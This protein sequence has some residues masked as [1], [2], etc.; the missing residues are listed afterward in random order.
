M[1]LASRLQAFRQLRRFDNRW[2]LLLQ[3][4]L[5]RRESLA[6][7]RLGRLR[8]LVDH[9]AGDPSGAPEVLTH[10]M[11]ADHRA[12]LVRSWPMRVLDLGANTGGFA[13]FLAHHGVRFEQL[14]AV[15]LNPRTCIRL[16]Y[17]LESNIPA[18]ITVVNAGVCGRSRDLEVRLGEGSVADSLYAPSFNST[19]DVSLVPGLTIDDIWTRHFDERPVDICKIDIE[20]AEYEVFDSP[21][22]ASL[23]RCRIV[24]IEIHEVPGRRAEEVVAAIRALGFEA[25]PQGEDRSVHVFRNTALAGDDGPSS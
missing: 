12:H 17:N 1:S 15:E 20:Q 2:Q 25:L 23:R 24:V 19:G 8:F 16:R 9:D 10:P 5:F 14:V 3:R 13:L 21:A 18:P 22:H 4:L 6:V 7:Y 11:Y